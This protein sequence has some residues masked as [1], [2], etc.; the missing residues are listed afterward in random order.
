MSRFT[1]ISFR[2]FVAVASLLCLTA[3]CMATNPP[4]GTREGSAELTPFVISPVTTEPD[5]LDGTRWKLVAFESKERT[6]HIPE[7]PQLF[8][9]FKKGG[10][11]FWGGCNHIGGY[12]LLENDH[13]TITFSEQTLVDCSASMPGI[14][15]VENAFFTAMQT[16][17]SYS[18]ADDRLCIRYADGELLFHRVSD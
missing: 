1:L 6:P 7:Q 5:P 3:S 8:V 9:E 2:L 18:I 4:E 10:L 14:N 15:E 17:E 11:G 13:I 16:F 12:Y